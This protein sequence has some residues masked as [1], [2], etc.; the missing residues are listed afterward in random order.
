M[1]KLSFLCGRL[2]GTLALLQRA[3]ACH[4]KPLRRIHNLIATALTISMLLSTLTA[5]CLSQT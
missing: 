5:L 4:A 3:E 1:H 2:H